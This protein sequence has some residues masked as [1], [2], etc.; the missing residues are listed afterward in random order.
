MI[1]FYIFHPFSRANIKVLDYLR[2]RFGKLVPMLV[3]TFVFKIILNE[4]R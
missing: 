1:M 2:S 3:S 4:Q